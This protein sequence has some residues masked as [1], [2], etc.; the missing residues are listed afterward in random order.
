MNIKNDINIFSP[1]DLTGKK[2]LILAGAKVHCKIVHAAKELGVYTIVTDY[3]PIKESPAKQ[4]ADEAWE[5]DIKDIRSIVNKCK[6][7]KVDGV[8][9]FCIDPAQIPYQQICEQLNIPC[10]GTKEQFA[11]F[12]NKRL[13]KDYCQQHGVD[14]IPEYSIEDVQNN[15]VEYPILVKP[16]ESRGSRGQTVCYSKEDVKK[17]IEIASN[18]SLDHKYLIE[19]YMLGKQDISLAYIIVDSTPYLVKI[20]DRF[21]GKVKD[22]LE[23]QQI[24]TVLPSLYAEEYKQ[25]VEPKV[26]S[27]IKS[28][29]MK[30][31]AIFLQGFWEDGHIYMY[32]PGL[33]FPGSDFD[34]VTKEITGFDSMKSFVYFALTGDVKSCFGN[35]INAYQYNHSICLILSIAVKP[36]KISSFKGFDC[37][38]KD[39][40]I[41]SAE[42]R[43]NINDII[44]ASGDIRQRVAEFVAHLSH[45]QDLRD[46]QSY[47]YENLKIYNQTNEDMIISKPNF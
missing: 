42:K 7:E 11:I 35:P 10:Y 26:I 39:S 9:S 19:R 5:I 1:K 15:K 18:E 2:I 40:R 14:V 46:F 30:F 31:G 4:I 44:P 23:K 3:L 28:L 33:R 13:F 38:A 37:L 41:F 8:L 29:G 20:G 6:Q 12:T 43:V 47:I 21:L 34:I 36:G 16:T 27:M 45:R 17:A 22:N 24:A 25:K 32:D